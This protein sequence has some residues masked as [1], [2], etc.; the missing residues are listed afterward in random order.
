MPRYSWE[1]RA[2]NGS[3]VRGDL[4]APSRDAAA[5]SLS[6]RGIT[7]VRVDEVAGSKTASS[8]EPGPS[9]PPR[10]YRPRESLRDMLFTFGVPLFFAALGVGAAW[11][12]PVLFYD[13]ARQANGSVDCT[14]HR[15]MYGVIPL[16]DLH[17][18]RIRSVDVHSGAHSETM[19]ERSRRLRLGGRESSYEVLQL[20]LADGSQWQSP[21]SAARREL[22]R[23]L[24]GLDGREGHADGLPRLLRPGRLHPPGARPAARDPPLRHE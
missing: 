11:I 15:R 7:V 17:F 16:G 8:A 13:C 14:V 20:T 10:G 23:D 6:S 19:A 12:D 4:E 18:S 1:G 22:A 21:E 9:P 3:L 2:T 24:S 5:Q